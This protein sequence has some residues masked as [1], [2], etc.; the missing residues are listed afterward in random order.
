[1]RHDAHYVEELAQSRPAPI[2]RMISVDK[3]DPNPDQPR[4]EIGDLTDLTNS[5]K[6]RGVLEPLLVKP[7]PNNG[8]WLIIAGERRWR[9]AREAG[10][11]EVPCVEMN[12]DDQ[13]V[14]EIALIEN[15]Q[16]KDLTPWEEADGLRALCE[17]FGYTHEDVAKK[18]G[19]SRSTVT[20]ALSIAA[21]PASIREICRASDITSKS[22]LLQ[23]VRQ[24]DDESMRAMAEQIGVEGLTRDGARKARRAFID[25]TGASEPYVYRYEAP[26]REFKV[27]V[28][29][30][31]ANISAEELFDALNAAAQNIDEAT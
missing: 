18:V 10:L 19:K 29:F 7:S 24:P 12:V 16:R 4:R 14:A 13:S 3:L 5:I 8:R 27:E 9:A 20:E 17:R 31:K 1:M 25:P 28:K 15:M 2:G 21:I 6:Q 11:H 22:L 23:I 26:G 30:K